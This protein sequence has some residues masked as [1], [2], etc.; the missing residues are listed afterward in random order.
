M[1]PDTPAKDAPLRPAQSPP[2][3]QISKTCWKG[4]PTL[5]T[6]AFR[7]AGLELS[8]DLSLLPGHMLSLQHHARM[9]QVQDL[10]KDYA[11]ARKLLKAMTN[12]DVRLM[13]SKRSI[14][15]GLKHWSKDKKLR[16]QG[17]IRFLRQETCRLF[18]FAK[19]A[20]ALNRKECTA[21]D[22]DDC[23]TDQD[24]ADDSE[25]ELSEEESDEEDEALI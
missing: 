23:N 21:G 5:L 14:Y 16:K 7:R 19:G 10:L 15:I 24:E 1:A 20:R 11:P 25:L 18:L 17:R 3:L 2:Q 4:C 8:T 22:D 12:L 6:D 9:Q 13:F